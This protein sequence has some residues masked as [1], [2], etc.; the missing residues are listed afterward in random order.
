MLLPSSGLM[1]VGSFQQPYMDLAVGSEWAG[2]GVFVQ[3][4]DQGAIQY[5]VIIWLRKEKC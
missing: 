2:E 4:K 5:G 1:Y 3:N